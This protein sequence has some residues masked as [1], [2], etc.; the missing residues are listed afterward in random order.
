[1]KINKIS[2]THGILSS[3]FLRVAGEEVDKI[4]EKIFEEIM[5]QTSKL[6]DKLY[7]S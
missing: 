5:T 7:T 2:E 6:K 4:E 1:M 3:L